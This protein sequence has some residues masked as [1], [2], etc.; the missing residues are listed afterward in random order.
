MTTDQQAPTIG[1]SSIAAILGLS[2]WAGPWDVWARLMGLTT[3]KGSRATLRGH[4][5][6]PAIANYYGKQNDCEL[7]PGPAYE[8]TP[9]IGPESWMHS[10]PDR[11]AKKDEEEWLVEIKSTRT[12]KDGWGQPG[13]PNVPQYYAAQCLWQMAV[14]GHS[15]TDLAAFATISDE[16]RVF[17]LHRD[18]GLE[19]KI[20]DYARDW[21][22]KYITAM[23]PP[24]VDS[25]KGC[26]IALGQHLKQASIDLLDPTDEDRA[27]ANDL[28][29]IRR[30]IS[31]L[32]ADK[33]MKENLL[34]ERIGENKGVMGVCTWAET[35]PRVTVDS[36]RLKDEHPEIYEQCSKVGQAGRQ[37]R[38]IY[39]PKEQ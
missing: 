19:K 31:E 27:L 17:T 23:T 35:K 14:T 9:I 4:I 33:R 15:R 1:S 37:F 39:Q 28:F 34:K 10:R 30:Q 2:P 7:T 18:E 36:K 38:F 5:L 13:T 20:V 32:E 11:F 12:F 21:Y 22:E 8:E 6:E 24:E 29:D 26:S 25:S 16:F 3:S